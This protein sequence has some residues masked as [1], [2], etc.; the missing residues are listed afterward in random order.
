MP[1]P[2][3][4]QTFDYDCGAAALQSV[5]MYY[6]IDVREDRLMKTAGTTTRGTSVAG[7]VRAARTHGL[8]C[9]SRSMTVEDV[10]TFLARR[11]PVIL[12][13]Q[14]WPERSRADWENMWDDG[15]YVVAVG[16]H[17]TTMMFADPSSIRPSTLTFRELE[18]RW[19]DKDSSGKKSIHWGIALSDRRPAD[20][21]RARR[22][23]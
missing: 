10:R 7:I 14:A 22:M 23:E 4:R 13:L 8:R 6:G 3:V 2:I 21:N 12:A 5:L 18:K 9:A 17:G 11:I 16:V 1:V 19:H 15:H 20:L